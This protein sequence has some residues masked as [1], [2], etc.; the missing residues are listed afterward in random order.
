DVLLRTIPGERFT[1]YTLARKLNAKV[2]L[3]SASFHRGRERYS[4]LLLKPAFT[5]QER[6]GDI[7]MT[8]DGRRFRLHSTGRDILDVLRY[9]ADQHA[10]AAHAAPP[11][12]A[13]AYV[14]RTSRLPVVRAHPFPF[15]VGGIGYLSY[16]YAA[17]FDTVR[18]HPKA[19]SLDLPDAYFVF[20]HVFVVFDHYTDSL[21]LV[22]V[23]YREHRIDLEE[24]LDETERRI[25]DLDFNFMAVSRSRPNATVCGSGDEEWYLDGVEF[26]RGEIIKGNLFQ[27]VLSRRLV[28]ET[29]LPALEAYRSLRSSNPSPYMFYLDYGDFQLF[30]ASP[31]VHVKVADGRAAM[32]P[33]AGTR[34]RGRDH[35]EDVALQEELLADEKELAE[36]LMLVDLARNDLGRVAEA[37]SVEVTERNVIEHY[38]H[39]MHIVS[40]VEADLRPGLTG[41]DAVR[42]TFPA[43]TVS[44]APKI[45]A[46]ETLD[47]LESETRGFYAGIVGYVE[48]GG[49]LDSCISIRSAVKKGGRL[50]LHAGAGVVYDSV[51]QSEFEETQNK[52]RALAAAVGVQL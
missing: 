27:A 34:R 2:L 18:L 50:V 11:G 17:Q 42:A 26:L 49:T 40:Q 13:G 8:R 28:I 25:D 23:N 19:D 1:P 6:K 33:I 10:E 32:R 22:G 36:H 47:A 46:M 35:R 7:T 9:F 24:A 31:E 52:L 43:G 44:G 14:S 5:I 38:S 15:P 29:E 4:I 20:G 48:P 45:Q 51:P 12:D 16:E 39:V 21:T 3:E 37:G 41:A 30:G